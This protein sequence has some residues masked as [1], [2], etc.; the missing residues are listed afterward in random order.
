MAHEIK[1][2][3]DVNTLVVFV[4]DLSMI[5]FVDKNKKEYKCKSDKEIKEYVIN[6]ELKKWKNS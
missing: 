5:V 3:K 6:R 4:S 2:I 1:I